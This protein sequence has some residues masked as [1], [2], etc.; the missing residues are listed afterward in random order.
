MAEPKIAAICDHGNGMSPGRPIR[1]R[2][3]PVSASA[4]SAAMLVAPAREA[5]ATRPR[6]AVEVVVERRTLTTYDL[7]YESPYEN[8]Y[9][10]VSGVP[11]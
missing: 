8:P 7:A 11:R 6:P 1:V 5:K 9:A 2:I 3:V 4:P 10:V